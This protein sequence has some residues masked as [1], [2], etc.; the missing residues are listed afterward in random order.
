MAHLALLGTR[1]KTTP[2]LAIERLRA[3]ITNTA[4]QS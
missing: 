4:V 1:A 2:F 3:V